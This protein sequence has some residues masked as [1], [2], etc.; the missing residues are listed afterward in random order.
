MIRI[1]LYN[2]KLPAGLIHQVLA[3]AAR[4]T[5][6]L[7]S[8]ASQ[9]R[10]ILYPIAQLYLQFET[11]ALLNWI[12]SPEGGRG[13]L[14]VAWDPAYPG[15]L[16]GFLLY[17]PL[18][19]STQHCGVNYGAVHE[20]FRG[21]GIYRELIRQMVARYPKATLTCFPASVPLYE[22]CGFRVERVSGSQVQMATVETDES[23][24]MPV[25]D[26]R[27]LE[28]HPAIIQARDEAIARHGSA[29]VEQAHADAERRLAELH[30]EAKAVVA[31]RIGAKG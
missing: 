1:A 9:E 20:A 2:D 21:R 12:G 27:Q 23:M 13:E 10:D 29:A 19:G 11:G 30:L 15:Q 24:R 26:L 6:D 7:S 4:Y 31:A 17:M 5:A 25:P 8:T 22:R 16:L 28:D 14:L 3:F 18:T